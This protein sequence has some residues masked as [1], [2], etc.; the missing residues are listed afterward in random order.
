MQRIKILEVFRDPDHL[1]LSNMSKL[2]IHSFSCVLDY[3]QF[4]LS[5]L[6]GF[7]LKGPT[8]GQCC[9]LQAKNIMISSC[10]SVVV[11]IGNDI[12]DAA[13]H[14]WLLP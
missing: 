9:C 1:G 6:P 3:A 8:R 7:L 13:Q 12:I 11:F 5:L 4:L 14:F 2:D 10:C